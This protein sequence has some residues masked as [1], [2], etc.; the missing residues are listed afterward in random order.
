[1]KAFTSTDGRRLSRRG[2]L[3]GG[4]ILS[5]AGLSLLAGPAAGGF[6][7]GKNKKKSGDP[8]ADAALINTAIA[9]EH[10]GIAAYQIAAE[11]GLLQPAV[12]EVG[13]L[14]QSHHKAHRD[15]LAQVVKTLGG[16]PV[17]AESQAFYAE[18]IE[19]SKLKNQADI[20]QLAIG[21][22]RGAANA[23]LGVLPGLADPDF[24]LLFARLAADEAMH[25][26][27]LKGAVGE[28]LPAN[29]LSFG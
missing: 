26:A 25:W 19:A 21:L 8:E 9:L 17:E 13:V 20:L 29:A 10:E 16:V 24:H 15:E 23:Y 27:A 12:L 3:A 1:M 6:L 2:A 5:V 7:G 14:F 22:E 28:A 11:S 18:R 4:G